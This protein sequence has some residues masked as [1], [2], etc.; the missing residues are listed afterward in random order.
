MK[1]STPNTLVGI[2]TVHI[3]IQIAS[4]TCA[5]AHRLPKNEFPLNHVFRENMKNRARWQEQ[6]C[7]YAKKTRK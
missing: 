5:L 2:P 4:S 7:L 1:E 3:F 6:V